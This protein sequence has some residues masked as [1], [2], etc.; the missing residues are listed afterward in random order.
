VKAG[1]RR[2]RLVE[3]LENRGVSLKKFIC[4]EGGEGCMRGEGGAKETP[5]G[6]IED[7]GTSKEYNGPLNRCHL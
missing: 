1:G 4:G 2:L 6:G 5:T 7:G 3:G